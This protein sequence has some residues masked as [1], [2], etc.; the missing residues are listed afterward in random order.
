MG[1]ALESASPGP[2]ENPSWRGWAIPYAAV[3]ATD[4]A[5]ATVYSCRRGR[6]CGPPCAQRC[7]FCRFST[8]KGGASQL[9]GNAET[10]SKR[11]Q[12]R[13][14]GSARGRP[15]PLPRSR[16]ITGTVPASPPRS[17][18][19]WAGR[20]PLQPPLRRP[21]ASACHGGRSAFGS[22]GTVKLQAQLPH[23]CH[24]RG[25][26]RPPC[27]SPRNRTRG[28]GRR[29]RASDTPRQRER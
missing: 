29:H 15:G 7:G 3:V 28:G 10:A 26:P 17:R 22:D 12:L 13:T 24:P 16:R 14:R 21:G 27:P 2:A 11:E 5:R 19:V 6:R 1:P 18:A 9:C 20:Q 23:H 8:N 25:F 4:D